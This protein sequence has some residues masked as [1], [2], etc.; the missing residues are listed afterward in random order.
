MCMYVI[1]SDLKIRGECSIVLMR[2]CSYSAIIGY[3]WL[4]Q[5]PVGIMRVVVV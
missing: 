5:L 4:V 3:L 1:I 2:G